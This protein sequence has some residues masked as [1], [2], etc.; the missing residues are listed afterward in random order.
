MTLL[1]VLIFLFFSRIQE[2]IVQFPRRRRAIRRF[3]N[4]R[5]GQNKTFSEFSFLKSIIIFSIFN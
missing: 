1:L 3:S 4:S 2:E 5:N